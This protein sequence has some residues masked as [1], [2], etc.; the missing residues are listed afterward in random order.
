VELVRRTSDV[1]SSFETGA[2]SPEEFAERL[3][4][5]WPLAVPHDHFLTAFESWSRALYD[6]ATELLDE[7]RP[8]YR[9]AALSNTNTLHWRR[10]RDVLGVPRLFERVFASHELG[11]R[12]P[13]LEVYEY[14]L[15]EMDVRP[16]ETTFFDDLEINVEAARRVGMRAYKVEGVDALRAC[17]RENGYL[18]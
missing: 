10:N 16:Q 18:A 14:V 17:L 6:G 12:K 9:L 3:A 7:L 8:S 4:V 11:L 5:H 15:A 1:W 2:L 13:A